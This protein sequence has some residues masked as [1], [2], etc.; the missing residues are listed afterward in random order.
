MS[1]RKIIDGVPIY[2]TIKEAF[3]WRIRNFVESSGADEVDSGREI[4]HVH[5]LTSGFGYMGGTSDMGGTE[6]PEPP[7]EPPPPPPPPPP[8]PQDVTD[9]SSDTGVNSGSSEGGY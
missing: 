9:T 5:K 4:A 2:S 8:V 7:P 1:V 3:A 6:P